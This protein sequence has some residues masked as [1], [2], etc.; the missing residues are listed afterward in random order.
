M[1]YLVLARKYRPRTFA[2]MVG[3][4][5][6]TRLLAGAIGEN[7][8][9][10]AY[11]FSGPRGT[12]KTTT[13]RIFAKA[14][15]CE[16]G[17]TP[18]P[19]GTCA[20][21]VACDAGNELDVIEIDAASNNGVDHVRSLRE[22]VS[23]APAA[24]R[25]K[26]YIID[27][28]HMMSKGAFNALLKTLEEP[29]A[30]VKFLFATTEL[31]KVPDTILSRCQ[32]LRLSPIKPEHITRRLDQVFEAEAIRAEAGVT[33]EIAARSRGGM[34]D[35]LSLADQLIA[36]A[37]D[38]PTLADIDRVGGG[39]PAGQMALLEHL[40]S[41][42]RGALLE[43]VAEQA[44]REGELV[45]GLLG[46]LRSAIVALH[47]GAGSPLVEGDGEALARFA[48]GVGAARLEW[49][50]GELLRTKDRMRFAPGLEGILVE[51]T[52]LDLARPEEPADFGE[53][54][55][56]LTALEARL[57]AATGAAPP[58]P[59]P[60]RPVGADRGAASVPTAPAAA[61]T[62]A[63]ASSAAPAPVRPQPQPAASPEP[64]AQAPRPVAPAPAKSP[65]TPAPAP[66]APAARAEPEPE[67]EPAAEPEHVLEPAARRPPSPSEGFAAA[68][69]LVENQR[70]SL[71]A[72]LRRGRV[73]R[74]GDRLT[75]AL[76]E[77]DAEDR[78]LLD[79]TRSMGV[80]RSALEQVFGERLDLVVVQA[81]RRGEEPEPTDGFTAEVVDL[82][83]GRI[84]DVRRSRP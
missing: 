27:E 80:A 3:Q 70:P 52:L 57:G 75:V 36:M 44:G 29:P 12:G 22:Q 84:E 72:L 15:N 66:P 81:D 65:A 51:S 82:F 21:C 63:A 56:R 30:H 13:A 42:A 35:A 31:H 55:E 41:G 60:A 23:Y 43:R 11:L 48:E 47:C 14:L 78:H 58:G 20:R 18:E 50:L 37:G 24:A 17:P 9:G 34:R 10:H 5:A 62:S 46:A 26:V 68:L 40:A 1:S 83:G 64:A 4:E 19:C 7:R 38:A 77:I 25:F 33:S 79:D 74:E 45:D 61:P 54:L 6:I 53:L 69:A 71:A 16:Q 73:T 49:W 2:D 59:A 76:I 8:I 39:G 67:T 32:V 28:V